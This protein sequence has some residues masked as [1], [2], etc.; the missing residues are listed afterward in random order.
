MRS[1]P[2]QRH[3]LGYVPLTA[4]TV[5]LS[6]CGGGSSS[7]S[8]STASPFNTT[9]T[10]QGIFL[11]SAV[12]GLQYSSN[13]TSGTTDA[14][15]AFDYVANETIHFS[16]GGIEIGSAQGSALITP[17][18]LAGDGASASDPYVLN[19]LR[20]LQTLDD[21]NNLSNGI[22]I[23]ETV[24]NLAE[25]LSLNFDTTTSEFEQN[26]AVI[27]ALDTLTAATNAGSR[28]IVDAT[29]AAEH[30]AATLSD[31]EIEIDGNL[32]SG[33]GEAISEEQAH[34][35]LSSLLANGGVWRFF[36]EVDL[37]IQTTFGTS[38]I[39]TTTSG[40]MTSIA[41]YRPAGN[42]TAE[43]FCTL[44]GFDIADLSADEDFDLD[45]GMGDDDTACAAGETEKI[46]YFQ[47][48]NSKLAVEVSCNDTVAFRTN[49]TKLSDSSVF[50]Q[51]S[52]NF[53]SDQ[54][55]ALTNTSTVCG[56]LTDVV[57]TS[58]VLSDDTNGFPSDSSV[59][60]WS[61]HLIA[62][63]Q[64]DNKI[65]LD[66]NLNGSS[67]VGTYTIGEIDNE[68][69]SA[70]IASAELSSP[71]FPGVQSA[72][73]GTVTIS[74]VTNFTASGSFDLF[75]TGGDHV[76]GNFNLDMSN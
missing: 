26:T 75:T 39:Q 68:A 24:R 27:A 13:S 8:I 35:L 71:V 21:D 62:P 32:P 73:S 5:M 69:P 3:R 11:D 74:S 52:L 23:T 14:T 61:V 31:I 12:T 55:N 4:F 29:E 18:T 51:G 38:V 37:N 66:F 46:T 17:L 60:T 7:S 20:F 25:G 28:N 63:Y 6:A 48:N 59:D 40:T 2:S 33:N 43:D 70:F 16:I 22:Q 54:F 44:E 65:Q 64:G 45:L 58:H 34:S 41:A 57:S 47:N 30:F 56:S 15:G 1:L 9:S 49:I 76:Q 36:N 53:T 42:D 50:S 67:R 10:Q 72:Q 19:V